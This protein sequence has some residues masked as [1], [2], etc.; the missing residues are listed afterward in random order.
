MR[1]IILKWRF[2]II[3]VVIM[4]I[5]SVT[6]FGAST[7]FENFD[8]ALNG[9]E[10]NTIQTSIELMPTG[11][12]PN[13]YLYSSSD[14]SWG[15]VGAVN[16]TEHYTG[17]YASIKKVSVDLMFIYDAFTEAWFRFRYHS[18]NYNGWKY[19]LTTSFTFGNWQTYS[20]VFDPTWSDSQAIAAGWVQEASSASFSET[21]AD[22][23]SAEVRV[24][25][26]GALA[27]GIDNFLLFGDCEIST[28]DSSSEI[29]HIPVVQVNGGN[30]YQV[31]FIHSY[32]LNFTLNDVV[33]I[34]CP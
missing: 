26:N 30:C 9:W 11:G 20:V 34:P 29:L 33:L 8:S 5:T 3:S 15:I 27:I 10:A 32:G 16:K 7:I 12:N 21:M 4:L 22:V 13:G 1:K 31:N 19:P 24:L 28:Y 17:D 2:F 18:A 14:G 6:A 25:G 23:Y